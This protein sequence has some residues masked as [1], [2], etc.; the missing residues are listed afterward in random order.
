MHSRDCL[1]SGPSPQS[2]HWRGGE[3]RGEGG[4]G[5]GRKGGEGREGRGEEREGGRGRWKDEH[6]MSTLIQ[7]DPGGK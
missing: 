3:G 2:P 4:G 1:R 6:I 5:R 7:G